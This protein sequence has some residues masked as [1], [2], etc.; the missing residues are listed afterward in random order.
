M[1]RCSAARIGRVFHPIPL[2]RFLRR[3][4]AAGVGGCGSAARL[5]LPLAQGLDLGACEIGIEAGGMRTQKHFPGPLRA[6]LLNQFIIRL[7]VTG[8]R[9][10]RHRRCR[11]QRDIA[12]AERPI[13]ER[14]LPAVG[15]LQNLVPDPA[16]SE[17][18][19]ETGNGEI[20][21]NRRRERA[22]LAIAV[23]RRRAG[24]R[25]IGDQG[26][27]AGRLDLAETRRYRAGGGLALPAH[28]LDEGIVAAGIEDDQPQALCAV[29]RRNQPL[30]RYRLVLGVAVA[31]QARIDRNEVIDAADF[32][33]M[34][35]VIDDGNIGLIGD[36]LELADRALEFEVTDIDQG[37]DRVE[38]GVAEHLGDRVRVPRWIGQLR[39]GL[40]ARIADDQRSSARA[41]LVASIIA[42]KNPPIAATNGSRRL[43][44]FI[45]AQ[46][47][48]APH[49]FRA[50]SGRNGGI[51]EICRPPNQYRFGC[52]RS[53]QTGASGPINQAIRQCICVYA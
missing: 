39:N 24:L 26:V 25:G 21:Q 53:I 34:A 3:H 44:I 16:E 43:N 6:D 30:Q 28:R 8:R 29:S 46:C 13:D 51:P 20:F 4:L 18:N 50:F 27:G 9:L 45:P 37:I 47:R 42:R 22:V 31:G 15:R 2:Q 10:S 36:R 38:A 5:T 11:H 19:I 41:A 48:S 1:N 35:G 40:V 7:D 32:E 23:V 14:L 33:T 49:P 12:A 17:A 52:S